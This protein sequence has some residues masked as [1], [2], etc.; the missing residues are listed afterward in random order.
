MLGPRANPRYSSATASST[1]EIE[2]SL[3]KVDAPDSMDRAPLVVF[4]SRCYA[5][6]RRE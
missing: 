4:G 2:Q 1:G 6:A 3:T 5:A